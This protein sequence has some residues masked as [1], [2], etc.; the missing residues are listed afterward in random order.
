MDREQIAEA[1]LE[2]FGLWARQLMPL[3]QGQS[4]SP[5][6][7]V[8]AGNTGQTST[9]SVHLC[10]KL[11]HLC[12]NLIHLCRNLIHLCT[13]LIYLC[14]NLIHLCTKLIYLC[15]NLIHL[16]TKLLYLCTNLILLCTKLIHLC[17]NLLRMG[18]GAG[19]KNSRFAF[20]KGNPVRI[21][22]FVNIKGASYDSC[23][24]QRISL[25]GW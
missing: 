11:I 10:R 20:F 13:K 21:I 14:R 25:M 23:E 22:I 8:R 12:T 7:L 9:N 4:L 2:G 6:L 5:V 17:R 19:W 24:R 18:K 3:D 16:C 15:T 1:V